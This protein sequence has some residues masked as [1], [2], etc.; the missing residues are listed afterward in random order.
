MGMKK[1]PIT[2]IIDDMVLAKDTLTNDGKILLTIGTVLKNK[3]KGILEKREITEVFIRTD[4]EDSTDMVA[5]EV[6]ENDKACD[7]NAEV[8]KKLESIFSKVRDNENMD[9]LF[10]LA[11]Q[12]A[13]KIK[14]NIK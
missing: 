14:A 3:H 2:E 9:R 10:D 12:K 11:L 5:D 7:D 8:K 4:D 6:P 13:D 1:I